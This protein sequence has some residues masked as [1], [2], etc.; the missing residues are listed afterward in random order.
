MRNKL[1]GYDLARIFARDDHAEDVL[2]NTI[3]IDNLKVLAR[4]A[5]RAGRA[6]LAVWAE[7]KS[8]QALQSLLERAW[9]PRRGLFFNLVG[10]ARHAPRRRRSSA[11]CRC[12]SR[13]CRAKSPSAC[14]PT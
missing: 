6:E 1:A 12:C 3:W 10:S 7:P 14:L 4:L 2:V 13:I 5:R 11:C 9:D 8:T